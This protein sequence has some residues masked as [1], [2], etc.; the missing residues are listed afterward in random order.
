MPIF[1]NVAAHT[2]T[3]T[4]LLILWHRIFF[5]RLCP[6]SLRLQHLKSL[7]DF[8]FQQ[9]QPTPRPLM[10]KEFLR[11]PQILVDANILNQDLA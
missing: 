4:L 6:D 3:D 7:I 1:A 10:N 5:T 11:I 9:C 8:Y 2:V